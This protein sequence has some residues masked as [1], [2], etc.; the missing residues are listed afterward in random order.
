MI[1][2]LKNSQRLSL[3]LAMI[4]FLAI[5]VSAYMLY[6]LPYDVLETAG[7][8][9]ALTKTY[10]TIALTFVFGAIAIF[11]AINSKK[12]LVVFKEK[13]LE[14]EKADDNSSTN[15]SKSTISL[16]SVKA[17]LS[18]SK[19]SK[20]LYQDFLHAVCKAI[21]AGQGAF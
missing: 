15:G 16:E 17:S 21:E 3:T 19:G 1:R 7:Y 12:E 8:G 9:S 10:L 2:Q 6:S 5:L 18:T 20:E 4:F 14:S 13:T 11:Y